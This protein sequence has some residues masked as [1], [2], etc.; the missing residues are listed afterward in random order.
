VEGDVTRGVAG[1]INKSFEHDGA[2][3]IIRLPK[4]INFAQDMSICLWINFT[5]LENGDTFLKQRRE[6][7]PSHWFDMGTTATSFTG[8]IN[9]SA[10]SDLYADSSADTYN[11]IP[12]TTGEWI[13]YCVILN[14]TGKTLKTYVNNSLQSSDTDASYT[15]GSWNVD[16]NFEI[17]GHTETWTGD[18]PTYIDGRID[19]IGIWNRTLSLSEMSDLYN[20]GSGMT[21]GEGFNL[22]LVSPSDLAVINDDNVTFVCN[23]NVTSTGYNITNGTLYIW[24]DTSGNLI[25]NITEDFG[26]DAQTE[27]LSKEYN[28]SSLEN[29]KWNCFGYVTNGTEI[30]SSWA[31][32]NYTFDLNDT[33]PPSF[34]FVSPSATSSTK[35]LNITVSVIELGGLSYCRYNI[36]KGASTEKANTEID[37]S[38]NTLNVSYTVSSDLTTYVINVWCNDTN[39]NFNETNLSVA[40]DTTGV[41]V[42]GGGGGVPSPVAS[43]SYQSLCVSYKIVFG[44]ARVL[45]Q[46]EEG[47]FEKIKLLWTAFWD[48]V[49]CASAS[50]IV[51]I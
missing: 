11:N 26:T 25:Y 20:N 28:F 47:I 22:D 41:G 3:D 39:S 30:I 45:A 24:N 35:T 48:Y 21:F 50:S 34:T 6:S 27:Q 33:I 13:F 5:S 29:Y 23:Y 51:P 10:G 32:S 9:P 43:V 12:I 1:K 15:G 37:V 2:G 38:D 31:D 44:D 18:P 17:M 36:T 49:L 42:V 4:K 14:H 7:V 19:E 8:G 16:F 40:V 46:Q